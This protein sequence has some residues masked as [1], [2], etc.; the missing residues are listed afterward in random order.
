M[1]WKITDEERLLQAF[2]MAD[3]PTLLQKLF[4]D[5]LT[6]KEY[7][8]LVNRL[9]IACLLDSC[10][11]YKEIESLTGQSSATISVIAKK[12]ANKKGGLYEIIKAFLSRGR[13]EAYF[14]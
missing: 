5:L 8:T 11:S 12:L 4:A 1:Y 13:N 9:K 10:A 7:I 6:D 3:E 2:M 14:D